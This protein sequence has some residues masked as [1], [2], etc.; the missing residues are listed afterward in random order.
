MTTENHRQQPPVEVNTIQRSKRLEDHF[1]VEKMSL[2]LLLFEKVTPNTRHSTAVASE[3]PSVYH[4]LSLMES[5]EKSQIFLLVQDPV[6]KLIGCD[7]GPICLIGIVSNFCPQR[8]IGH[9]QSE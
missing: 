3:R 2:L 8:P 1:M 7:V 9:S 4:K 5:F 6:L